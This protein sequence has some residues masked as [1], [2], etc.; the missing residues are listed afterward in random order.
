[1]HAIYFD[2]G[3]RHIKS[4]GLNNRFLFVA[5]PTFQQNLKRIVKRD[6]VG[7]ITWAIYARSDLYGDGDGPH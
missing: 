3:Q 6:L 7:Q 1:M 4:L 2:N 5:K